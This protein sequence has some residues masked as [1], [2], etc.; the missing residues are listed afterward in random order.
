VSGVAYSWGCSLKTG[1]PPFGCD[2]LYHSGV[3]A[4]PNLSLFEAE[5]P[6]EDERK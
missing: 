5:L 1:H 6:D 3:A 4:L 2:D